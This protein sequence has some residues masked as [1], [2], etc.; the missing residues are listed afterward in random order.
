MKTKNINSTAGK[1]SVLRQ[2]CNL[3]PTH[4]VGKL[5]TQCGGR[6][7]NRVKMAV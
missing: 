1:L 7:E 2:I 4:L 5:V 3:I 6:D